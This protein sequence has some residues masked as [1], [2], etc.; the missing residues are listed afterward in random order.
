MLSTEACKEYLAGITL[1]DK[2]IENLRGALY[3]LVENVLDDYIE[4]FVTIE[5]TCKNQ[6]SIAESHLSDKKLK[7]TD[8]K[9]KSIVVAS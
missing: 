7:V 9:A 2:Q 8:W 6:L 5:P 4:S 3:A 1:T